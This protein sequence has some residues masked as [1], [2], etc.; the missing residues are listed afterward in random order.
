MDAITIYIPTFHING[1]GSYNNYS[2]IAN[3]V[4]TNNSKQEQ[5]ADLVEYQ[6]VYGYRV[7]AHIAVQVSWEVR[8]GTWKGALSRYDGYMA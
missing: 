5:N 7:I 3:V 6:R 4:K 2:A 1:I 8:G